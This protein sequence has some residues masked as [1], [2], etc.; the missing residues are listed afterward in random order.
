MK[1]SVAVVGGGIAG[2]Q[3]ALD[4]A[5]SGFKTYLIESRPSIGGT[6]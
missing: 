4:L 6:M 5:D 3:A 1:G 2:I